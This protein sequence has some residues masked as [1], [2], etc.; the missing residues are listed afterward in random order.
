MTFTR[1][2]GSAWT[3]YPPSLRVT[4][5]RAEEWVENSIGSREEVAKIGGVGGPQISLEMANDANDI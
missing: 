4:L 3:A 5:A 1:L 2:G